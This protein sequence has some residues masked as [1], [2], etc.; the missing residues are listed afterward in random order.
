MLSERDLEELNQATRL[1]V[2]II[3]RHHVHDED[4][5]DRRRQFQLYVSKEVKKEEQEKEFEKISETKGIVIF[6]EKEILQM[7]KNKRNYF[8]ISGRKVSWRKTVHGVFEVRKQIDGVQYYGASTNLKEAK[9]RFID[10]LKTRELLE[11]RRQES[12]QAAKAT[13]SQNLALNATSQA[14]DVESYAYDYLATFKKPNICERAYRGYE[15]VI[16]N[17]I[18]PTFGGRGIDEITA[19]DCQQLLNR[20]RDDGKKRTAESVRSLL[21]WIFAAA[22]MDKYINQ[23][24]MLAVKIPKHRRDHGQQIP[25]E[26]V[27]EFLSN[28]PKRKYDAL[29]RF[30]LFTGIRPCEIASAVFDGDFVTIKNAKQRPGE[31][32]TFR[33]IPLHPIIAGEIEEIKTLLH[34]HLDKIRLA[35]RN[36]FPDGYRLYDLRHTFTS[37]IQECGATKEWVDYVTNHVGA[38]NVTD[39]VYTHWSDDFH[40]KQMRLLDF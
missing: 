27:R 29:L 32:P 4:A 12:L 14:P 36:S 34:G 35:F 22:V 15:N 39:R 5:A 19:T 2:G 23:N 31:D 20:L 16:K 6:S 25:R 21:N 3:E 30:L 1:L 7:P 13:V 40:R 37:R 10:D 26:I 8:R 18:A 17:H 38:Q 9:A 33:R 28:P 24:P 11:V